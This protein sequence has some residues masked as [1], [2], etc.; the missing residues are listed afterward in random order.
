MSEILDLLWMF[1]EYAMPCQPSTAL[2]S[3]MKYIFISILHFL[4][5][6]VGEWQ[7]SKVLELAS[8]KRHQSMLLYGRGEDGPS[9]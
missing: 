3:F 6:R 7:N 1:A 4:V 8:R 2:Q 5:F 9:Q